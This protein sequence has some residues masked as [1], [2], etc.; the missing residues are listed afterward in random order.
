MRPASSPVLRIRIVGFGRGGGTAG[1]Q[2]EPRRLARG[3]KQVPRANAHLGSLHQ[4]IPIND[5]SGH[6]N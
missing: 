2:V 3:T 1:A 4:R 5:V 6:D